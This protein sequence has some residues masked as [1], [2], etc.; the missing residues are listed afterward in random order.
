MKNGAFLMVQWLRIHLT[1]LGT[2]VRLLVW[3]DP[4]CP[5]ATKPMHDY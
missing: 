3:E 2:Q 1:M 4:A 5:R